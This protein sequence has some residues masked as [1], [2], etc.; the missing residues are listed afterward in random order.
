MFVLESVARLF[1]LYVCRRHRTPYKQVYMSRALCKPWLWYRVVLRVPG[2]HQHEEHPEKKHKGAGREIPSC[3]G[4]QKRKNT[5]YTVGH[6]WGICS[7]SGIDAVPIYFGAFY[8]RLS[9]FISWYREL[10]GLVKICRIQHWLTMGLLPDT[11]NYGL[12]MRRKCWERFLCHRLQRKPLVSDPGMHHGT[13]VTHVPLCMSGSLT[14]SD[15]ENV[16][17]IP[18][19]CATCNFCVTGKR[20]IALPIR[21]AGNTLCTVWLQIRLI[22]SGQTVSEVKYMYMYISMGPTWVLSAPDGPMLAP[23]TLLSGYVYCWHG[24]V[25][26]RGTYKDIANSFMSLISSLSLLYYCH[27]YRYHSHYWYCN[28]HNYHLYHYYRYH[29]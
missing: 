17:G 27:Y 15:G 2:Q 6:W 4:N 3:T 21:D 22:I 8:E 7:A 28:H 9:A 20:P 25:M 16:P 26:G 24:T 5:I 29:H 19:A 12:R 18:G 13:C 23:W 10:L 1:Y 11:K 14:R